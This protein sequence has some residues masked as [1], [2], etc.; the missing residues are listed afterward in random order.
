MGCG[1]LLQGEEEGN[2]HVGH[3]G[4]SDRLEKHTDLRDGERASGWKTRQA[5]TPGEFSF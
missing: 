2:T 3:E 5:L 1:R 4:R